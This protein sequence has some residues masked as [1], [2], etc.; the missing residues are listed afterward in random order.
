MQAF[1]RTSPVGTGHLINGLY[2]TRCS[3]CGGTHVQP[4]AA[5]TNDEFTA[6]TRSIAAQLY[7]GKVNTGYIDKELYRKTADRLMAGMHKAFG[8]ASFDYYDKRNE[9]AAYLQHNLHSF[10]AAKS[11]AEMMHFNELL[12]GADG[13]PHTRSQ[14]I[15]AAVDAGYVFNKNHLATE[16]DTVYSSAQT[17]MEFDSFGDDDAIQ[18]STA[19]DD[20]V[21]DEHALLDGF[22]A[23]KSNRIWEKMCPPFDYYC[24]CRL[25]PGVVSRIYDGNGYELMRQAEIKPYFQRNTALHRVVWDNGH[26][27][28]QIVGGKLK[29]LAAVKNY[30]MPTPQKLYQDN[31]FPAAELLA[32]KDEA[33]NWWTQ[34]AGVLRG[35]I[36]MEDKTG[37]TVRFTNNFRNHIFEDNVD[38]RW[39]LVSNIKA[40]ITDPDE[41]WSIK[42]N[43]LLVKYYIRYFEDYPHVVK[44]DGVEAAT[45]YRVDDNT[46]DKMAQLRR[47]ALLYKK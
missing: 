1:F 40:I 33:N 18:I 6:I 14:F 38:D 15:N 21:R 41:V 20:K 19:G 31:E 26:P 16:Y 24:R 12:I 23:K 25:V 43:G 22:T 2:T 44:V 7:D 3:V 42:E 39:R 9:L 4:V 10:S 34:Q 28:Y 27:Y 5:A 37:I 29:E 47:G 36:D 8:A 45:F 11:L 13:N 35:H 46:I 32:S 30:N 17:A